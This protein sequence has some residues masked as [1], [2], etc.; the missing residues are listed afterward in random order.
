MIIMRTTCVS[1]RG[2]WKFARPQAKGLHPGDAGL[3]PQAPTATRCNPPS[4]EN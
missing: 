3:L 1:C 2:E 4:S